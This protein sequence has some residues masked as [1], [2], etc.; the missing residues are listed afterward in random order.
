MELILKLIVQPLENDNLLSGGTMDVRDMK[1]IKNY[2]LYTGSGYQNRNRGG[3]WYFDLTSGDRYYV[4]PSNY[5]YNDINF[6]A[7]FSTSS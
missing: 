4:L 5:N 2:L 3:L 1:I 6:G 7:I